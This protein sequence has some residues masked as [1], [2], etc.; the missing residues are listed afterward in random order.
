[1]TSKLLGCLL[2]TG[3]RL[4]PLAGS[5]DLAVRGLQ[6]EPKLASMVFADL[7]L[8]RHHISSGSSGVLTSITLTQPGGATAGTVRAGRASNTVWITRSAKPCGAEGLDPDD[9]AVV[10]AIDLVRWELS[11]LDE[12]TD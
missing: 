11:M 7:E 2:S 8:G 12:L 9:P 5:D 4:I 10:A 1:L 3:L 6:V